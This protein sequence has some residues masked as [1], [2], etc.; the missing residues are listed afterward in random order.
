MVGAS[1]A[2]A[3]RHALTDVDVSILV[4]ESFSPTSA[5][6]SSPSFDAR[7]TAL[8]YGTS[9]IYSNIGLWQQL[10]S[11]ATPIKEI[12][13]S[14]KG[15]FGSAR[16]TSEEQSVEALGF[17]IENQALGQCLNSE[18]DESDELQFLCP[19][20]IKKITPEANG[21][22]LELEVESQQYV[23]SAK[24]VVLADGGKSPICEQLGITRDITSYEQQALIANV[25]FEKPH[26][27]IAFERFTDTGPLAVLPLASVEGQNRCS[28]VWTLN[29][30]QVDEYQS[31]SEDE[32]RARLQERFGNKLGR[33]LHIG[34]RFCYPLSLAIAKEQIRPGL[35]L[36]GNVA[37]TLHPVAG[38]GL[39]LAMRDVEMLVTTLRTALREGKSPGSMQVLQHYLQVQQ[40]DQDRAIGFTDYATKLFSSNNSAKVLARKF[41][42]LSIDLVPALRRELAKHAMGLA[43]RRQT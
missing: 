40:A 24:L 27:N 33:V 42:L 2:C 26:H 38:Q 32:L 23:L 29:T 20:A 41:G 34:E 31:L 39:N 4:I 28:L 17:V 36:L 14:D 8:S 30:Q 13:I 22:S 19:A 21:M 16:I 6:I 7:S 3:L 35:V 43:A 15:R 5:K 1:F 12:Q 10:S 11:S 37:H 9:Q 18:L 25:A